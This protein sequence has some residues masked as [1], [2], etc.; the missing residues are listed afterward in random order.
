MIL[1]NFVP[2]K[3]IR[4]GSKRFDKYFG[5]NWNFS[6]YLFRIALLYLCIG[7]YWL[8]KLFHWLCISEPFDFI[9][10]LI[11]YSK[12][13]HVISKCLIK[14]I[15]FTEVSSFVRG[16]CVIFTNAPYFFIALNMRIDDSDVK[17]YDNKD[18]DSRFRCATCEIPLS[19]KRKTRLLY[20]QF[21]P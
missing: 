10:F 16:H 21:G 1:F 6:I 20:S 4:T 18:V 7:S 3:R 14:S 9:N 11:F 15:I 19:L 17:A 13:K 8:F 5:Y 12:L 2:P